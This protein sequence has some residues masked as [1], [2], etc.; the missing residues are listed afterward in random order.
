MLEL[1]P[2]LEGIHNT[3]HVCYLRNYEGGE[4]NMIPLSELRIDVDKRLI[5][6]PEA[7]IDRKTKKLQLKMIGLVLVR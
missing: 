4:L 7:I 6:N 3:F 5:E 2:E 1:S